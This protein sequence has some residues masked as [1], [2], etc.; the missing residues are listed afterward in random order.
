MLTFTV[1][2]M[3]CS[4]CEHAVRDAVLEAAPGAR[5]AVDLATKTVVVE[6]VEA[7]AAA[8]IAAAIREAGYEPTPAA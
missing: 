8:P 5:V 1:P 4:H 6:G 3:S 7:G 2:D